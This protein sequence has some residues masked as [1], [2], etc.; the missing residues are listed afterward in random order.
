L[1]AKQEA[2]QRGTAHT[3]QSQSEQA[4]RRN[5]KLSIM[6]HGRPSKLHANVAMARILLLASFMPTWPNANEN[7]SHYQCAREDDVVV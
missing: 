3:A 4:A 7:D 5:Y 1:H 6:H 2:C